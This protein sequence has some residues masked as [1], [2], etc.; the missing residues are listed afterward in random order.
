MSTCDPC[1]VDVMDKKTWRKL[2]LM[3]R[4]SFDPKWVGCAWGN[5]QTI[6]ARVVIAVQRLLCQMCRTRHVKA[7]RPGLNPNNLSRHRLPPPSNPISGINGP[8]APWKC[9]PKMGREFLVSV[10]TSSGSLTCLVNLFPHL[11][12]Q[13]FDVMLG[14]D[15]FNYCSAASQDA[16]ISLSDGCRLVFS[17]SPF[18]AVSAQLDPSEYNIKSCFIYPLLTTFTSLKRCN[19][20]SW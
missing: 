18:H 19:I 16:H 4:G 2:N 7:A 3:W 15:W 11:G 9:F 6:N 10:H 17:A 14:R 8:P 20:E 12:S 5:H 1:H 13:N